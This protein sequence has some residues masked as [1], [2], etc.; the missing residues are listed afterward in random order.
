MKSIWC[1]SSILFITSTCS[2]PLQVHHQEEQLY[3][4]DTWYLLFCI[5][6][7]LVRSMNPASCI[8]LYLCDTWY[9]LFCI[10]DC[11]VR[12]M[13][14]A[15]CIQLYVCD[16]WYLLFC[17][18]DCLVCRMHPASCIQLYLC[19]TWYLLFCIAAWSA[20]C[21]LRTVVP[22]DDG[23]GEVRNM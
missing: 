13:N 3:V 8:Q 21:I 19:D 18:A 7:C 5:A 12:S 9:L 20:G 14:P 15:S 2:G 11:L 10:A 1:I 6:D 23:P 17:I 4:C 16:T 22:P